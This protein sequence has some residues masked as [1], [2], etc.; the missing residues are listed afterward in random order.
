MSRR[1]SLLYFLLV[2]LPYVGLLAYTCYIYPQLPD[3]FSS[4]IPRLALLGAV[5]IAAILPLTHGV[6]VLGF[7]QYLKHVHSLTIS[8]LMAG[9]LLLFFYVVHLLGSR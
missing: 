9:A 8:L 1:S 7:R 3:K 4:G 2:L 6:L 5:G